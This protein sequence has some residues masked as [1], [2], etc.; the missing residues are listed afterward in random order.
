MQPFF[1]G[2]S[3]SKLDGEM[4]LLW[5]YRHSSTHHFHLQFLLPFLT[6][7]CEGLKSANVPN[8][9]MARA[10]EKNRPPLKRETFFM[11]SWFIN[12][13]SSVCSYLLLSLVISSAS[14]FDGEM[15]HHWLFAVGVIQ[16]HIKIVKEM[17]RT[18]PL[19]HL[20]ATYRVAGKFG[21]DFNFAIW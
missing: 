6:T 17:W 19:L 14:K 10:D 21:E 5:S 12:C 7:S 16:C 4:T 11:C 2:S 18:K 15:H 1:E 20:S 9:F 8:E 3:A 13:G